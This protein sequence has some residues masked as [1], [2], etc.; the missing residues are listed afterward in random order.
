MIIYSN[1]LIIHAIRIKLTCRPLW[2]ISS[3]F[4]ITKFLLVI[5]YNPIKLILSA[6]CLNRHSAHERFLHSTHNDQTNRTSFQGID[7]F[8][9][10][11]NLRTIIHKSQP[12]SLTTLTFLSHHE[13]F[14]RR[15]WYTDLPDP[16]WYDDQ[17]SHQENGRRHESCLRPFFWC[18]GWSSHQ[19]PEELSTSF[20]WWRSRNETKTSR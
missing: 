13:T 14:V 9:W 8:G 10:Y 6:A 3:W 20:F 16:A 18:D 5:W 4:Q 1:W 12:N 19:D 2:P 17:P 7:S 11:K 15:S